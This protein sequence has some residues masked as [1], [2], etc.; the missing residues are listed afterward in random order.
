MKQ[1]FCRRNRFEE[2][3]T[4]SHQKK[5]LWI[6]TF[7]LSNKC[8]YGLKDT[9]LKLYK[10][11]WKIHLWKHSAVLFPAQ[12]TRSNRNFDCACGWLSLGKMFFKK[13]VI[14]KLKKILNVDKESFKYLSLYTSQ[15]GNDITLN[16]REYAW[17][18]K[19]IAIDR[20]R[21]K[22]L[23]LT[24]AEKSILQP[25]VEQLLWLVNL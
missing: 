14:I 22:D 12:F 17:M 11:Q 18:L 19:P 10:K 4:F 3:Y 23:P 7:W 21:L 6:K 8:I 9:L 20:H 2:T 25:K 5:Q 16:Q 13:M 24:S 15:N 1:D